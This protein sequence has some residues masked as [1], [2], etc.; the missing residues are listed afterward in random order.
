MLDR[1]Q[2]AGFTLNFEK[3]TIAASEIKYLGH[4]LSSKGISVLPDRVAAI[5]SYPRPSNLRTLRRFLGMVGFYARFIPNFS[6]C[7][8]VLHALK[9]KGSQFIWTSEHQAA[10]EAFK[11]AL[12]ETP[13]LQIPDLNKDFVLVTNASDLAISAVLNQ[14]VREHLALIAYYSSLLSPAQRNY[15]T[16]EKECLAVLSGCEKF[17]PYLEH[18]EFELHCDNLA[19]CWLLKRV[20]EI[21]RLGRWILR[22][23]PLKFRVV[24]TKGSENVVADALSRIFKGTAQKSPEMMCTAILQ[25]LPLVYSSLY[26]HQLNDEFC[27]NIRQ[28]IA[29][30]LPGTENFQI[31]K[32][33]LCYV[34]RGSKHSRWL[35]PLIL[36]S[37]VLKYFNDSVF[38]GHLGAVNTFLKVAANFWWPKIRREVFRYVRKCGLCQRA[39]PAQDT[40]AGL[41]AAQPPSLLME[42]VFVDFVGPL[43]R[44]KRGNSAILAVLDGFSKFVV[45]YPVRKISSQVV[46]DSLERNY[47]PMYQTTQAIVTDNASVFQCKQVKQ[48]CFKWA[49]TH[50]TT[51][52]YY[53][54]GSLVERAN[55]NLKSALKVFH[56]QSQNRWDEDLP[57]ISAAFNTAVHESSKFTPDILFLGREIKSPL[58][59]RWD[60]SS[61]D[62]ATKGMTSQSFWTQAYC[63][64]KA[65]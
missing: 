29:S 28:K 1:L 8:A 12:T 61:H 37:M 13:V 35:A 5:H 55:R 34:P 62:E 56:H 4:L 51:T 7:A 27:T 20:K 22:L 58:I 40:N 2:G 21:G 16:Y 32:D 45:F 43:T 19:L 14:R 52:L 57:W 64:L 24:R 60:L 44:T 63:N 6:K 10:F 41:H 15:S 30:G 47:F 33:L 46:V 25:S 42:K 39:K 9:R 18:K 3:V 54:Q 38:A 36:R 48:M 65:V 17:R 49:I 26:E 11:T 23:A 50:I 59:T 31:R 53:P